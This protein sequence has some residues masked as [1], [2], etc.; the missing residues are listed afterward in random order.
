MPNGVDL[1]L[2]Y[3]RNQTL[4]GFNGYEDT[5]AK[6]DLGD[7]GVSWSLTLNQIAK[8]LNA[9]FGVDEQVFWG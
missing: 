8:I 5:H 2:V 6:L 4:A 9:S 1:L 3:H 7:V